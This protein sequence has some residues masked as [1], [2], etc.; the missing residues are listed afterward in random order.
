MTPER[1]FIYEIFKLLNTHQPDPKRIE[2]SK[3]Y[4]SSVKDEITTELR[5]EVLESRMKDGPT[6]SCDD[7]LATLS[8][9]YEKTIDAET[10][11]TAGEELSRDELSEE[12][13]IEA[14]PESNNIQQQWGK[15]K[16]K[17]MHDLIGDDLW[18]LGREKWEERDI[19]RLRDE[20]KRLL[21]KKAR[22]RR[23]IINGVAEK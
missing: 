20:A 1:Q 8:E 22:V 18:T 15:L 4:I 10:P 12:A 23:C 17:I 14:E 2:F 13:P 19:L 7:I 5:R 6:T 21:V 11:D 16:K 9:V 3:N